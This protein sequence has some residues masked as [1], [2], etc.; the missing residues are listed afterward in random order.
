MKRKVNYKP[1][2]G[3]YTQNVPNKKPNPRLRPIQKPKQSGGGW[4]ADLVNDPVE[5]LC[6]TGLCVVVCWLITLFR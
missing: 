2:G 3:A 5:L 1:G 4:A 6:F